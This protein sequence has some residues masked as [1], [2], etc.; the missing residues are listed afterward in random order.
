MKKEYSFLLYVIAILSVILVS[1]VFRNYTIAI[2]APMPFGSA[3][4]ILLLFSNLLYEIFRGKSPQVISNQGH[5][6]INTT[7]DIKRIPLQSSLMNEKDKDLITIGDFFL[8][9]PGGVEA[10]GLSVKSTSDYPIYLFPANHAEKEDE[11]YRIT[12][13]LVKTE[14]A[15]LPRYFRYA[16]SPYKRRIKP[17]STPIY[18]GITSHIDGSATPSNVKSVVDSLSDN[19][20]ITSLENKLKTLYKELRRDSEKRSRT[21][22]IKESGEVK[23]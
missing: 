2:P 21:F 14:F 6:S 3:F 16:L 8:M 19:K 20:M 1:Y 23:E 18:Y 7:K 13:N 12:S 22:L 9:F 11:S 15:E 17:G 5:H 10:W 4:I